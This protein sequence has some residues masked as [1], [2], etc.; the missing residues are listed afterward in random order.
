MRHT[1]A[2]G[3]LHC[4]A[5]APVQRI[6]DP[7]GEPATPPRIAPARGPPSWEEED[8]GAI[9]VDD[10]RFSADPLAQFEPAYEFDQR[11]TW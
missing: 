4:P 10:R 2:H 3:C 7:I 8:C 9:F 1:D 6:L 11:I 5:A